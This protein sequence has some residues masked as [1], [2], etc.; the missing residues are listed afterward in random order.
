MQSIE[1]LWAEADLV[2][3]LYLPNKDGRST[4][5]GNWVGKGLKCIKLSGRRF[6]REED[7]VAFFNGQVPLT[8]PDSVRFKSRGIEKKPGGLHDE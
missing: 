8:V 3:R 1:E 4:Q 2:K 5:I 6:F 7:I